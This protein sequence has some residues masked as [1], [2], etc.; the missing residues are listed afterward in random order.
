MI[1]NTAFKI[2]SHFSNRKTTFHVLKEMTSNKVVVPFPYTNRTMSN[3][4][5]LHINET[6]VNT[7]I[8]SS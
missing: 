8:Y 6:E 3:A 1:V 5:V 4:C 7:F 2:I